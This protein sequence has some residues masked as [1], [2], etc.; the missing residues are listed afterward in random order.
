MLASALKPEAEVSDFIEF[1]RLVWRYPGA[2]AEA[3]RERFGLTNT[4]Y[5][6]QLNALID[7][8]EAYKADPMLVKRLRERRVTRSKRQ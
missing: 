7:T 4:Q 5:Y 2:K 6:Q 3:I 1:E 8:E